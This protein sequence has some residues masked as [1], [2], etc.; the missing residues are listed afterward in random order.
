VGDDRLAEALDL[1]RRLALGLE[2]AAHQA[3]GVVADAQ[4]PGGA[5]CSMRAATLT[6]MPRMLPSASTPPPSSTSPVC[7]PTR[8]PKPP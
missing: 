2:R 1:D 6:V 5:L 4:P 7:T 8:T 3:E